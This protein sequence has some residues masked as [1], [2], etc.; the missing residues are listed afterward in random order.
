M[1][2]EAIVDLFIPTGFSVKVMETGNNGIRKR[3]A[4]RR[5]TAICRKPEMK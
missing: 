2:R 5:K 3:K 4:G 1:S